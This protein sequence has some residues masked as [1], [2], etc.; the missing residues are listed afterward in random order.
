MVCETP[1]RAGRVVYRL[2]P[3]TVAILPPRD[4]DPDPIASL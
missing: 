2:V 1:L 4:D 3:G